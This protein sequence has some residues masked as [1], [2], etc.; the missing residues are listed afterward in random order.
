MTTSETTENFNEEKCSLV[1]SFL[2]V[3]ALVVVL[4]SAGQ[5]N[6]LNNST[7]GFRVIFGA[8]F[9]FDFADIILGRQGNEEITVTH[10]QDMTQP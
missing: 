10:S 1:Q 8:W 5:L 7:N 2:V 4:K 6:F 3:N 9:K